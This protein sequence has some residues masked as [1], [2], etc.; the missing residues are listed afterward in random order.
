MQRRSGQV[1]ATAGRPSGRGRTRR[2]HRSRLPSRH[3]HPPCHDRHRPPCRLRRRA[4]RAGTRRPRR[5]REL[6][7]LLNIVAG[8]RGMGRAA[9]R[10]G[11]HHR[12][13]RRATADGAPCTKTCRA[14]VGPA[15]DPPSKK[16]NELLA[17]QLAETTGLEI[18]NFRISG[19]WGPLGHEDPFF[20]APALIHAAAP[21]TAPTFGSCPVHPEDALDLCYVKDTGRAI[22]LLAA[23][24]PP[25]SPHLQRRL[26]P[27]DDQHRHHPAIRTVLP[28][29]DLTFPAAARDR[30]PP[31]HHPDPPRT[32]A[33]GPNTTPSVQP[34]TTSPGF[35]PATSDSENTLGRKRQRDW[36]FPTWWVALSC[37]ARRRRTRPSSW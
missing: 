37:T 25:Q 15:P 27:S 28:D 32:P 11:Q 14:T 13:L 4:A 19:T 1:P 16:I 5:P 2:R 8:R 3:R 34:R 22:A 17:E 36:P 21:G 18:I 31:R 33:T 7:G 35:A 10:G 30:E 26:R 23:G 12:C 6:D 29:A 9:G 24:P 20:A